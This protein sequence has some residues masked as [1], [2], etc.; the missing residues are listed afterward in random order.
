MK[1]LGYAPEALADLRDIAFYIAEDDPDR[2]LSFVAE[3]ERKAAD[4]ATRPTSFRERIEISPGLR[5]VVHGRYLIC[6]RDT[7]DEVRIVR[8]V[9]S[10]RDLPSLFDS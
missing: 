10:A 9:H 7:A 3:L 5:A 1:R 2:A 8:I 6:F 4:A